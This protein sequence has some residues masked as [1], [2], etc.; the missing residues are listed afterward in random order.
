M[1]SN[2]EHIDHRE[3]ELATALDALG[4]AERGAA[5]AGLADRVFAATSSLIDAP[6]PIRVARGR[7]VTHRWAKWGLGAGLAA[8]AA[9]VIGVLSLGLPAPTPTDPGAVVAVVS[10]EA[11]LESDLETWS[12]LESA[13]EPG[14]G[15]FA[16]LTDAIDNAQGSIDLTSDE[17]FRATGAL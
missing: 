11:A 7:P 14:T 2:S 15:D 13:I 10:L 6:A 17:L 3:R 1:N 8:A 4:R 12:L 9:L 16:M 5:P